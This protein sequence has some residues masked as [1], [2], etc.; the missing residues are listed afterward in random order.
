[1]LGRIK[2][3]AILFKHPLKRVLA[4]VN[5]DSPGFVPIAIHK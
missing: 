2:F 4:K 5:Q 3:L 1:M